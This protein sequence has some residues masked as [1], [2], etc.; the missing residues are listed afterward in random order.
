MKWFCYILRCL[1]NGHT[2][3]TYN[4]STNDLSRRIRQ[5]NGEIS[6]GAKATKG[7]QWEFY[8]IMTGF[9]NHANTLSCEWRIKRPTNKK[10]R[11]LKYCG[12][13][14]RIA[15]LNEVLCQEKWT[16]QCTINNSDCEYTLY[17]H[18]DVVNELN[19]T[20]IPPNINIVIIDNFNNEFIQQ[21]NN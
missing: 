4:G 12:V 2:N 5:H 7:K 17:I 14:G 1:D 8:A 19:Q 9:V 11:P 16:Q 21:I 3:L 13:K 20:I 6:G 10:K 15:G 18:R